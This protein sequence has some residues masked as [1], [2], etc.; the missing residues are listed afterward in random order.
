MQQQLLEDTVFS[1]EFAATQSNVPCNNF[2][3]AVRCGAHS[4]MSFCCSLSLPL[5]CVSIAF[6][7]SILHSLP[8]TCS[9]SLSV[10][11]LPTHSVCLCLCPEEGVSNEHFLVWMR[12]AAFSTV[13]NLVGRINTTLEQGQTL[14]LTIQSSFPLPCQSD[15]A[16]KLIAP[17]LDKCKKQSIQRV[18]CQ[19][20]P[21]VPLA[22]TCVEMCGETHVLPLLILQ[23]CS[24]LFLVS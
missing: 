5:L 13:T 24:T 4:H 23:L 10:S 21:Q 2:S 22:L 7:T 20:R 12:P 16:Y 19:C 17:T 8:C 18:P 15:D 3:N 1:A 14:E 9:L 6:K 11:P